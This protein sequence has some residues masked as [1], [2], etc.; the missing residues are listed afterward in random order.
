MPP[1]SS[2]S[3]A[4]LLD[5]ARDARA[6]FTVDQPEPFI[7][8]QALDSLCMALEFYKS[9]EPGLGSANLS[10]LEDHH[11]PC[12]KALN[13]V[14]D[15]QRKYHNQMQ[16]AL[17]RLL[18]EGN[19]LQSTLHAMQVRQADT[20][21]YGSG[22]RE[23][24]CQHSHPDAQPCRNGAACKDQ[25]C[26]FKHPRVPPCQFGA[27]CT[28]PGCT[29]THP[30]AI[31]CRSGSVCK[32]PDCSF[33][34]PKPANCRHG[35]A[36]KSKKCKFSHPE[37][38]DCQNGAACK[39]PNCTFTHPEAIESDCKLG[40]GCN[41]KDCKFDHPQPSLPPPYAET[42]N[43]AEGSS[44]GLKG[45]HAKGNSKGNSKGRRPKSAIAPEKKPR[46][47]A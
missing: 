33:T 37:A 40:D 5:C 38:M 35:P 43:E 8:K 17:L 3:S 16:A 9:L 14:V 13:S 23:P 34:H 26:A 10:S 29:F 6:K 19:R 28:T 11:D 41:R 31:A 27:G 2:T 36:C 25:P 24:D 42:R 32:T 7:A 15:I 18:E 47:W 20:C 21:R 22:C 45:K 39:T 30:E 12:Q 4:A 46:E 44:P 1:V